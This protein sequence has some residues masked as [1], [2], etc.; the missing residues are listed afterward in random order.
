MGG[1]HRVRSGSESDLQS[2]VSTVPT[3][4]AIDASH[5]SFQLYSGGVYDEPACSSSALDHGVW[6]SATAT[7]TGSSRTPGAQDGARPDTSRCPRTSKTSAVSLQW[8]AT[9]R[10]KTSL[11]LSSLFQFFRKN[12]CS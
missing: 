5:Y 2:A 7:T 8:L 3:S 9:Q 4:V 1:A 10:L 12:T 6:P 11:I